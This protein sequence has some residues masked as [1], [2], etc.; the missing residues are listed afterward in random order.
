M[1]QAA[2]DGARSVD[3]VDTAFLRAADAGVADLLKA[4]ALLVATLRE[5]RWHGGHGQGFP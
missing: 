2:C 4:D 3:D 1:A 5:F